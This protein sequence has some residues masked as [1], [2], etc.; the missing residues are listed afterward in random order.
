MNAHAEINW[1]MV[2]SRHQNTTDS[3]LV[4][5]SKEHAEAVAKAK[6]FDYPCL[7]PFSIIEFKAVA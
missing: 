4:Y 7:A 5:P 6:D 1:W 2:I 3:R